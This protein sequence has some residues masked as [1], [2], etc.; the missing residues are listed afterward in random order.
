MTNFSSDLSVQK[1]KSSNKDKGFFANHFKLIL[2]I[3]LVLLCLA[4]LII[5]IRG[6][7]RK[8]QPKGGKC[9]TEPDEN[10]EDPIHLSNLLDLEEEERITINGYCYN[11]YSIYK[12]LIQLNNELDPNRIPVSSEDRKRLIKEYEIIKILQIPPDERITINDRC[13][14]IDNIYNRLVIENNN[15]DLYRQPVNLRDVKRIPG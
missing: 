3:I 4:F 2:I 1:D 7:G 5:F 15:V 12:W 11:I 13:F 14:K 10:Y 8:R 9:D 6:K